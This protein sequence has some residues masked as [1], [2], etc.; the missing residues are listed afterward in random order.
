MKIIKYIFLWTGTAV[1]T[2]LIIFMMQDDIKIPQKEITMVID[3]KNKVN[4]CL[5]DDEEEFDQKSFF[6][7]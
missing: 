4:I 1:V 3:M 6:G 2:A 7:F 5:P